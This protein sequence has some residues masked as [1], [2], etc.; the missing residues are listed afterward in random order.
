MARQLCGKTCVDRDRDKPP[1]AGRHAVRV[2]LRDRSDAPPGLSLRRTSG[3]ASVCFDWC[4]SASHI[5]PSPAAWRLATASCSRF[6]ATAL[7]RNFPAR[8]GEGVLNG[9]RR[10]PS[11]RAAMKSYALCRLPRCRSPPSATSPP[12]FSAS[13]I[14]LVS[15]GCP[16][17]RIPGSRPRHA[18]GMMSALLLSR[19]PAS[20]STPYS[21]ARSFIRYASRHL[22]RL[23]LWIVKRILLCDIYANVLCLDCCRENIDQLFP[24][25][26]RQS[27]RGVEM[28]DRIAFQRIS[29]LDQCRDIRSEIRALLLHRCEKVHRSYPAIADSIRPP[30]MHQPSHGRPR[31]AVATGASPLKGMIFTSTPLA[32]NTARDRTSVIVPVP[33]MPSDSFSRLLAR[34]LDE[35]LRK[36]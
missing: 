2:R 26:R 31:I 20:R 12:S 10:A 30:K 8:L 6:W 14:R 22:T 19:G 25:S 15:S 7:P 29:Q 5:L 36:S 23:H 24:H 34:P 35:I 18:P 17:T 4:G 28:L 11:G 3:R 32:R 1:R 13:A 21:L 9:L 27:L 16:G 33:G